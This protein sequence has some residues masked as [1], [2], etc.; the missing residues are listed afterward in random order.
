MNSN[1]KVP[2]LNLSDYLSKNKELKEKFV[3]DL[4]NSFKQYGFVV[5]KNH[6]IDP[7]L[8][9]KIYKLQEKLFQLPEDVK[10][11]YVGPAG[12]GGS[13]GYTPFGTEKAKDAKL[14]DLKEFW[15]IGKENVIPNIWPKEIPK[16]QETYEEL[17][18]QLDQ[19]GNTLLSA[20][21]E[22]LG[23]S[24][25][26]LAE[27]VKD[28]RS[29]L[30][31]LH[32]PPVPKGVDPNQVRASA[33]TDICL[34][35]LLLSS[36]AS[37]LELLDADGEWV[38]IEADSNSIVINLGDMASRICNLN[39]PSTVH[40]VTNP[41]PEK[42]ISRYSI[43]YFIHPREEIV[44]NL[45]PKFKDEELKMPLTTAKEYLDERLKE[46]GLLKK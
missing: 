6:T 12:G 28:G 46:I 39:L 43:P 37:G 35:T 20:L 11:K 23:Y 13:R 5:I 8:I 22:S 2:A 14:V 45:A 21:S 26:H 34:L 36:T 27:I 19:I 41:N 10:R 31:L 16:F 1:K 4:Y 33:H 7:N 15:H 3:K 18:S 24:N 29:L 30:R 9:S 42:N 40:R 17:I 32:Y 38:K 25:N 44:L